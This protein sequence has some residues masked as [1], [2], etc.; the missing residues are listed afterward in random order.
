M[1]FRPVIPTGGLAGW[2]YLSRTYDAQRESFASAEL[3]KRD[4]QYFR[5]NIASVE[6]AAD[7]VADRTLLK[8]ALGAYG[9]DDDINK[10]ALL[11][12]VLEEGTTDPDSLANRL[13]DKRYAGLAESFGFDDPNGPRSKEAGFAETVL[14]EYETQQ[15]EIA[16]GDVD[17]SMRFALAL[18]RGLETVVDSGSTDRTHW[19]SV[20]ATTSLREVF[21]VAF[22]LPSTFAAIDIDRQL[23]MLQQKAEAYLGATTVAEIS[24]PENSDKLRRLYLAKAQISGTDATSSNPALALLQGTGSASGI[25][26]LLYSA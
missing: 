23:T 3:F 20:M 21:E 1:T 5:D 22:G 16:V 25:L 24:L 8:V 15:F 11:R 17:E 26:S 9:L 14:A 19:Y 13:P 2:S 6:T 10:R 7:L 12:K 4:A 18:E